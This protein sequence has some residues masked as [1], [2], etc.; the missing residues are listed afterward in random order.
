MC[1][2]ETKVQIMTPY[3]D[4]GADKQEKIEFNM[5]LSRARSAVEHAF[6]IFAKRWCIFL[7]TIEAEYGFCDSLDKTFIL[8]VI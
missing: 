8:L 5:R 6:G 1:Y 7:G 3:T 4:K 2:L